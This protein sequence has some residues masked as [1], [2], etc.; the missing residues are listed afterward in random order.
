MIGWGN[1]LEKRLNKSIMV[2]HSDEQEKH[3]VGYIAK[4][5]KQKVSEIRQEDVPSSMT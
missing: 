5:T 3:D 4:R 1:M 2:I